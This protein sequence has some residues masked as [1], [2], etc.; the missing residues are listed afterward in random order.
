VSIRVF[1]Q[2]AENE[3]KGIMEQ[4]ANTQ[5]KEEISETQ[6]LE[7]KDGGVT[8]GSS[9][10]YSGKCSEGSSESSWRAVTMRNEPL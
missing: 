9:C 2:A 3:C 1:C 10:T 5:V 8:P 4:L 6:P 7:K